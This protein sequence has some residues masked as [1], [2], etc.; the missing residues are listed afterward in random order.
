MKNLNQ[1]TQHSIFPCF[2]LNA[3][4][5]V[6]VN[7]TAA[8]VAVFEPLSYFYVCFVCVYVS[9]CEAFCMSWEMMD[10]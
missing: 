9:G 2:V 1:D 3:R 5:F 7:A 10:L 8:A 4:S 6:I